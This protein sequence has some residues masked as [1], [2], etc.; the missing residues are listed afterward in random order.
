M[1]SRGPDKLERPQNQQGSANAPKDNEPPSQRGRLDFLLGVKQSLQR[2]KSETTKETEADEKRT[3][4]FV[5]MR[6]NRERSNMITIGQLIDEKGASFDLG[7]I[8]RN[9]QTRGAID[10]VSLV[11]FRTESG[12]IYRLDSQGNLINANETAKHPE[13]EQVTKLDKKDLETRKLIVGEQFAY[14]RGNTARITEIVPTDAYLR[15]ADKWSSTKT[16]TIQQEFEKKVPQTAL[17]GRALEPP[18]Q[19]Y[20]R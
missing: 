19:R 9:D 5:T 1:D 7:N 3:G 17:E 15:P 16:S 20:I 4:T 13:R 11:Y 18:S 2:Q 14:G 12:N 8:Y 10:Y 6:S